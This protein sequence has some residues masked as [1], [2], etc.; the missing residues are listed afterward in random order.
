MLAVHLIM[1]GF[2]LRL[3]AHYMNCLRQSEQL[4]LLISLHLIV[5][6]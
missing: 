6:Q 4:Q 5:L 1:L 2:I 3:F